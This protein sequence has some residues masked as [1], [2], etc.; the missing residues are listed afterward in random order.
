MPHKCR[1]MLE[2][3]RDLKINKDDIEPLTYEDESD[4]IEN[5]IIVERLHL[6]LLLKRFKQEVIDQD[7]LFDWIHF[8]WFSDYFT[9]A[10]EDADCITS[11]I[12]KL[13]ELEEEGHVKPEDAERCLYALDINEP[14]YE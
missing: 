8:V 6:T 5:P 12:Q 3:V 11:V 1:E 10:D 9:C 2:K 7:D 4:L 13:E 14:I